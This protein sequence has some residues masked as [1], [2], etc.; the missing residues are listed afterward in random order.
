MLEISNFHQWFRNFRI[1]FWK[2]AKNLE[3][4]KWKWSFGFGSGSNTLLN[5]L[6]LQKK[7]NKQ[8]RKIN[9]E[10]NMSNKQ[11]DFVLFGRLLL[12]IPVRLPND[13]DEKPYYLMT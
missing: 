13:I 11:A 9:E 8:E 5:R 3:P 2:R 10:T 6:D 4:A 7:E 1:R 12:F